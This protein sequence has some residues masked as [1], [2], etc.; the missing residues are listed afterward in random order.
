MHLNY[1]SFKK[2]FRIPYLYEETLISFYK[3]REDFYSAN[4]AEVSECIVTVIGN[5]LLPSS[6]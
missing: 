4:D 2:L 5:Y 6:E 1:V 3:V